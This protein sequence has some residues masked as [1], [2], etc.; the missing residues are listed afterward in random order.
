MSN[1]PRGRKQVIAPDHAVNTLSSIPHPRTEQLNTQAYT[2]H[3]FV[4][5]YKM[6]CAL[7]LLNK[8]IRLE[9]PHNRDVL[10][11]VWSILT[12]Y[13]SS[14]SVRRERDTGETTM[15]QRYSRIWFH[16]VYVLYKCVVLASM[17]VE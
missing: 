12:R 10:V 3:I 8:L 4:D 9:L 16:D 14:P 7:W 6:A 2:E 1:T 5:T 11:T 15:V 13:A 17:L